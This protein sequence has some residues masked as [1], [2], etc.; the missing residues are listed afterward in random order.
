MM[1][2]FTLKYFFKKCSYKLHEQILYTCYI[3]IGLML[4][5]ILMKIL[6]LIR[7]VGLKSVLF[8]SIVIH[9]KAL[10]FNHRSVK[11]FMTY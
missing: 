10:G 1:I 6:M 3:M 7:Q 9:T 8:F 2:Y 4:L 11:A 5:K